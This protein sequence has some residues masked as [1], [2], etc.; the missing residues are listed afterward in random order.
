MS[1]VEKAKL[2]VKKADEA[3]NDWLTA[4]MKSGDGKDGKNGDDSLMYEF[5]R[6][7]AEKLYWSGK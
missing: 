1:T 4:V 5:K 7:E 6:L 2:M 3:G